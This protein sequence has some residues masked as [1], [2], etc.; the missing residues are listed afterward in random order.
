MS[1]KQILI[2]ALLFIPLILLYFEKVHFNQSGI[3]KRHKFEEKKV[4]IIQDTFS[5]TN[6]GQTSNQIHQNSITLSSNCFHEARSYMEMSNEEFLEI[7]KQKSQKL[8]SECNNEIFQKLPDL[9]SLVIDFSNTC[10]QKKLNELIENVE[11]FIHKFAKNKN[12]NKDK[13]KKHEIDND[14]IQFCREVLYGNYEETL[15]Y[16]LNHLEEIEEFKY[17]ILKDFLSKNAFYSHIK[18]LNLTKAITQ[19]ILVF[20]ESQSPTFKSII[21]YSIFELISKKIHDQ[22]FDFSKSLKDNLALNE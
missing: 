9:K 12:K 16:I 19:E 7:H 8:F 22:E 1:K 4:L 6:N 5:K 21:N 18:N 2:I 17:T 15:L 11:E 10:R 20:I 14:R 13:K 3:E